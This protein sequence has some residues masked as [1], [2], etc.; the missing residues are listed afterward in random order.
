MQMMVCRILSLSLSLSLSHTHTHTHTHTH[1][2]MHRERERGTV[3]SCL[4]KKIGKLKSF[5]DKEN[6]H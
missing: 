6:S 3:D 1:M 4:Y 5:A 2:Y